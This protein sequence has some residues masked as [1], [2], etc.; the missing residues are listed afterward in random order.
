MD[1]RFLEEVV[2][3]LFP[4]AT[5]EEDSL[6]TDEEKQEPQPSEEEPRDTAGSWSPEGSPR[7]NWPRMSEGSEH[8]KLRVP[9]ESRPACGRTSPESWREVMGVIGLEESLVSLTITI[10]LL[11]SVV[12]TSAPKARYRYRLE[13]TS[14]RFG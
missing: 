3:T 9:T 10:Y 12:Y 5:G 7:K 6:F 13:I 4:G 1:L 8:G 2:G 14:S 11:M